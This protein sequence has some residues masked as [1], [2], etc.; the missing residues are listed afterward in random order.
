MQC[1][2]PKKLKKSTKQEEKPTKQNKTYIQNRNS[3][4]KFIENYKKTG[5]VKFN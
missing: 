5:K 2:I 1:K 3:I 4:R